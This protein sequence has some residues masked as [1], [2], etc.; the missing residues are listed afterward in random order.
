M[1]F[2]FVDEGGVH[3]LTPLILTQPIRGGPFDICNINENDDT[4]CLC[5]LAWDQGVQTFRHVERQAG[6]RAELVD[7]GNAV[8]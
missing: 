3:N 7:T 8:C 5:P 1:P 4:W 2:D 6:G